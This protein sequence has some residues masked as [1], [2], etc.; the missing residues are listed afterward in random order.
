MLSLQVASG[1]IAGGGG[2]ASLLGVSGGSGVAPYDYT[3]TRLSDGADI[4][5]GQITALQLSTASLDF[6]GL[7]DDGYTL[8]L[9]ETQAPFATGQETFFLSCGYAGGGGSPSQPG[10]PLVLDFATATAA[11]ASGGGTLTIQASGGVAPLTALVPSFSLADTQPATSGQP[12]TFTRIAPGYYTIRVQDSAQPPRYVE[13]ELLVEPYVPTVQG[14]RDEYALNFDPAANQDASPNTCTYAP[15]FVSA[16]GAAGVP[17]AVEAPAG[18]DRAYLTATLRVGFRPGHPRAADRPLGE[19]LTLRATVGPDGYATF[20]LAPYLRAALGSP[21]GRGGYRLDAGDPDQASAAYVGY[22]LR[23]A[24]SPATLWG[25]GY[26]LN[27][28]V[29]SA[30]LTPGRLLTAFPR[31]P[32]WPGYVYSRLQ[33][34]TSNAGRYG[35]VIDS[36]VPGPGQ[37]VNLPCPPQPLPVCWLNPYGGFDYW[38]FQGRT[39]L[40]DAGEEG[41]AYQEAGTGER[42]YSERGAYRRTYAARSGPLRGA[43]LAEG[44]ATL[45]RSPQVWL[46]PTPGAAWVPVTLPTDTYAVRQLGVARAE[47]ALTFTAAAAFAAQGQ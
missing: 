40:A 25:H 37:T 42:R 22:E 36:G 12:N 17:V 8:R 44:L 34:A 38:V 10:G 47:Y 43:D 9:R 16:W 14:C 11:T 35:L 33:L 46:Q 24:G 29:P 18:Y 1:C 31:V 3:L 23:A 45:W 30:A 26:A 39:A 2:Y 4:A 32:A 7:Y 19:A 5:S 15:Q 27:A 20:Q 6:D 21:D 41:Q 13:Q 28:A